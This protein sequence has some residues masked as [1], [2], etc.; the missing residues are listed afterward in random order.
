MNKNLISLAVA[1]VLGL[2]ASVASAEDA[3]QG[4][5]Y[6]L[7]GV[8]YMHADSDLDADNGA[9][10]FLRL[11]KELSEHWDVQLGL[12]HA[13]ADEDLN[14]VGGGG[15]FKQTL[16]GVDALYMF[17]RDR[18]RPF[19]LAGLGL[20][21]NN[22]DYDVSGVDIGNSKTSWMANVGLGAQ[23]MATESLGLQADLRHVW[24]RADAKSNATAVGGMNFN[25]S[26]TVGNTYLNLGVIWKFGAPKPVAAAEPEPMPAPEPVAEPEPMPEP[27]PAAPVAFEKITLAS[28][29]LFDFDKDNV[30]E[31]GKRILDADVVEKMKAH[32]EVELVLISGHSDR[33]GSA[34]YN[35]NLSERRANNVKKYLISQS[36][37]E[38]RLHT[39]GKGETEPVV[40]CKGIRGQAAIDCLQPNRRVVVEIE[41][42]R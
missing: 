20:A 40:D 16:L 11:G 32:P 28:E 27:A 2:S 34:G 38:S 36:I 13:R 30:K 9:G 18:F 37:E 14:V 39:I 24:S 19:V 3:Y 22:I 23:F 33:I 5:W 6:V 41:E 29:V 15:R 35:Q 25:D 1:G 8:S 31:A 42:Q 26:E 4:A 17:S 7:P 21:H 12:S 10:G